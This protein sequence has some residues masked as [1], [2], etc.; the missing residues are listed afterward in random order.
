MAATTLSVFKP[1]GVTTGRALGRSALVLAL[2]LLVLFMAWH[3]A[4]MA[5]TVTEDTFMRYILAF[6]A[7]MT[8]G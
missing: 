1:W 7:V 3:L 5:C 4:P 2:G 8:A 6:V